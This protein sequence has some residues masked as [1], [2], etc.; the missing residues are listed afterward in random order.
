MSELPELKLHYP[1]N[2]PTILQFRKDADQTGL[3]GDFYN[4]SG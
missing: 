3:T 2:F 4:I 1:W